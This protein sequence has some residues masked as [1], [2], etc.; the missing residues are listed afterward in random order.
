MIN[1][2][3]EWIIFD[4]EVIYKLNVVFFFGVVEF[5]FFDGFYVMIRDLV[6]GRILKE[7][8][9]LNDGKIVRFLF[10]FDL[11]GVIEFDFVMVCKIFLCVGIYIIKGDVVNGLGIGSFY[12][13]MQLVI[14]FC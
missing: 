2:I 3:K 5:C 10:M 4:I 8:Q 14:D 13:E 12:V 11:L 1:S 6:N 7:I 9:I